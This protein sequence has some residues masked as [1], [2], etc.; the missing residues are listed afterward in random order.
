MIGFALGLVVV[1]SLAARPLLRLASL[2]QEM[3]SSMAS[4]RRVSALMGL[5]LGDLGGEA[6]SGSDMQH[7]RPSR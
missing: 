7:L 3:G 2:A 6:H 1:L 4:V 5:P